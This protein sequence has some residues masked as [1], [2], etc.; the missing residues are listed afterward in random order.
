MIRP[1]RE[2]WLATTFSWLFPGLG[3]LYAGMRRRGVCLLILAVVLRVLAVVCAISIQIS[4]WTFVLV[5]AVGNFILPIW[6]ARDAFRNTRSWNTCDFEKERTAG[7]DPW[8]AVFLSVLLRGLGHLYL[9]RWFTGMFLIVAFTALFVVPRVSGLVFMPW[10]GLL[11]FITTFLLS[12]FVLAHSY[13]AALSRRGGWKTRSVTPLLL[14][15]ATYCVIDLLMPFTVGRFFVAYMIGIGPS[16]APTFNERGAHMLLDRFTYRWRDPAVGEIVSLV[17]PK[18]SY[19]PKHFNATKR[20]VAVGGETVQVVNYRVYVNGKEREPL[21][22]V[23][24]GLDVISDESE[25]D[26]PYYAYGV[27]EPYLVPEGRYFVLGDNRTNSLDSRCYGGV[28]R[29]NIVGRVVKSHGLYGRAR[30]PK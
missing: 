29:K 18:N 16:M 15:V 30:I 7:K 6:A 27:R 28:P 21:S 24:R 10:A 4:F 23:H 19:S 3:H 14:L 11:L 5:S 2:P 12:I 13:V 1:D 25:S 9:R 26:N 20:I 22:R 8:L 17:P